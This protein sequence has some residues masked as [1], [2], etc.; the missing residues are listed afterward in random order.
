MTANTVNSVFLV[1]RES[2]AHEVGGFGQKIVADMLGAFPLI[3]RRKTL[4]N[5]GA[6]NIVVL[7]GFMVNG[8]WVPFN[9]SDYAKERR[10]P[11]L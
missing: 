8:A 3:A 7:K 2:H 4:V 9:P 6:A 11:R 5:E 1:N 10:F